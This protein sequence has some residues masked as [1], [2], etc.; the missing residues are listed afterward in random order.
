MARN[1][2]KEVR[3]GNILFCENNGTYYLLLAKH[4][5]HLWAVRTWI[6]D[7]NDEVCDES[8]GYLTDSEINSKFFRIWAIGDD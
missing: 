2:K 3:P 1:A 5:E 6:L 7:E 4:N 8:K